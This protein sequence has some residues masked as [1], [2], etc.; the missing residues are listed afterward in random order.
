MNSRW[1]LLR[2]LLT[3]HVWFAAVLWLPLMVLSALIVVGIE[4][5]GQVDRSVWHYLATQAPRWLALGLAVDA[6]NTYLRL[7]VA[8]GH[9]RRDF[10]RQLWPYLP[11]MAAALALMVTVGYQIERGVY[12]LT[13]WPH[14]LRSPALFGDSGNVLGTFGV[15]TLVFLLW[16]VVGAMVA[17]AFARDRLLGILTL[18]LGL[19][20]AAPSLALADVSEDPLFT[21]LTAPLDLPVPT[22]VAVGL[23]GA[24]VACAVIWGLVRDMPIRVRQS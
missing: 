16:A 8:H 10:L 17:A 12:A 13:G 1:P 11:A 6:I 20:V 21:R 22:S 23:A 18:P 9:T 7:H 4:I 5:W 3:A 24:V 2:V 14:A 15:Y 19:L